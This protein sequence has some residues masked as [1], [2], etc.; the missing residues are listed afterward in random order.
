MK[1]GLLGSQLL[2]TTVFN[3]EFPALS[4]KTGKTVINHSEL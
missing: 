3:V 1:R 2:L 4:V